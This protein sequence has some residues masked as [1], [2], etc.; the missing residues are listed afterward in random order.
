MARDDD[1]RRALVIGATGIAGQALSR[2]L[3]D[4]GW[5]VWG[6]SRRGSSPVEEVRG[7]AADLLDADGLAAALGD[8]APDAVFITAW[9]RQETEAENIRINSAI[10]RNILDAVRPAGTVRHVALLTGLKHY[11][12]PFEDYASGV[13]AE[14]PF[15]EDEPRLD[16]PNFYYA[17]ED[18]LFDA[19]ARDGFTWS[20]HRAHTVF[21]FAT[22][23]AMNM[24]LTL[25]VYA[26]IC[27]RFGEVFR[28]PGSSTQWNGITDVT[29]A[30]LLAEQLAWAATSP[31]AAN[32]A[33]NIAN[34]DVFRW[35]WLWPRIAERF[36]VEWEGFS[37][38]PAPLEPRMGDAAD[39]WRT[40]AEENGLVEADVSRLASWWH[41]DGD[42]GRDIECF[43]SMDKSRQAGFLAFRTT[44]ESF[45]D[46]VERYRAARIIP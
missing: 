14:T 33:F 30:D 45:F 34:G 36:G 44:P 42:L 43:T 16:T 9:M 1:G 18:E 5:E 7:V 46:K 6:L 10:V 11:L 40:I 25:S 23:N 13:M 32:Q 27:A 31:A 15:H 4:D 24:A 28:F 29:D 37:E 21:G 26:S 8:V 17:Q 35:R 38:E 2:R 3:L 22:G 41:T 39:K 20:V 12:G 19:A